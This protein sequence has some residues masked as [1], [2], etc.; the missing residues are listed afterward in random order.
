MIRDL[1]TK[2]AHERLSKD[3][4]LQAA[5][6]AG[7]DREAAQRT[8]QTVQDEL[9]AEHAARKQVEEAL[10]EALEG[11]QT[12]ERNLRRM[13]GQEP[14]QASLGEPGPNVTETKSDAVPERQ[15]EGEPYTAALGLVRKRR[16]AARRTTEASRGRSTDV[17]AKD[18]E[19]V[20]WWKP[21][22][23]DRFR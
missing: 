10:A 21:G 9:A 13:A 22:W 19:Y 17:G 20:E 15:I 18:S 5:E 16:K 14:S 6:R 11:R 4:V 3:E 12:A 23:K 7:A 1:Q 8:L 2:L